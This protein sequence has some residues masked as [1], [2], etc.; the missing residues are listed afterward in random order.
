[1]DEGRGP[2]GRSDDEPSF[3]RRRIRY[4]DVAVAGDAHPFV[5]RAIIDPRTESKRGA[6]AAG[7]ATGALQHA[8]DGSFEP[9]EGV[10]GATALRGEQDVADVVTGRRRC[11][12]I[13]Q[14]EI[15]VTAA[16]A[17]RAAVHDDRTLAA[18]QGPRSE[19]HTSELQSQSNLVCRLLLEKKKDAT[20]T[21][22]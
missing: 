12:R 10:D 6:E 20:C 8:P 21:D 15:A 14:D 4:A 13:H 17:G 2:A 1:M 22:V 3:R 16:A 11:G 9:S 5:D 7:A 19:E 18:A